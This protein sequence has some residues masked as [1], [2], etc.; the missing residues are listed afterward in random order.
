MSD[1]EQEAE[2]TIT[3]DASEA[4]PSVRQHIKVPKLLE[5]SAV[6]V[7]LAPYSYAA[8]TAMDWRCSPPELSITVSGHCT[9]GQ[10][11]LY[12]VECS[13]AAFKEPFTWH[14]TLRLK[15]IRQGLHDVVKTQLG[16]SYQ[17]YF[18]RIPFA[19]RGRPAGTTARLDAWCKRLAYCINAKLLPPVAMA[20]VLRLTSVPEAPAP[21]ST[22]SRSPQ[23]STLD[24]GKLLSRSLYVDVAESLTSCG[25]SSAED[26][27]LASSSS[28]T[29]PSNELSASVSIDSYCPAKYVAVDL[30]EVRV[31]SACIAKLK[32]CAGPPATDDV[33]AAILGGLDDDSESQ[34]GYGVDGAPVAACA[35]DSEALVGVRQEESPDWPAPAS[36]E[37]ASTCTGGGRSDS[38]SSGSS[39]ED[40]GEDGAAR[41]GKALRKV[42]LGEADRDVSPEGR[43]RMQKRL[44]ER[45]KLVDSQATTGRGK[46]F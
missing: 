33:S 2:S 39:A 19:H 6:P 18:I 4:D 30:P 37:G 11:T 9:V 44:S 45:R 1:D 25:Q 35:D 36:V 42:A 15:H 43:S 32:D 5:G 27:T 12:H 21:V 10:H 13:L 40:S 46:I 34:D 16:S 29:S 26:A 23:R 24:S 8:S 20:A 38:D 31:S 17:T 14:A 3:A 7:F 22:S 41:V 28:A